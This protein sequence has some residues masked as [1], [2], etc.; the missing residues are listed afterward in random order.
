VSHDNAED[1][2]D[3]RLRIKVT[4]KIIVKMVCVC[5]SVCQHQYMSTAPYQSSRLLPGGRLPSS[6]SH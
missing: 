1:K 3:C 4:W 6:V 5:V 2:K